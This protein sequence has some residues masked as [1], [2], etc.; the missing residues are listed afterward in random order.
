VKEVNDVRNP[1]LRPR[2]EQRPRRKSID[3][4]RLQVARQSAEREAS[5]PRII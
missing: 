2:L 5:W 4:V 3:V 1:L